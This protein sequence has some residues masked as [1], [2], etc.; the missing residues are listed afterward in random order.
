MTDVEDTCDKRGVETPLFNL[1]VKSRS[2]AELSVFGLS[3]GWWSTLSRLLSLCTQAV[4]VC[5]CTLGLVALVGWPV[6]NASIVTHLNKKPSFVTVCEELEF[7]GFEYGWP[8]ASTPTYCS[9]IL[10]QIHV[11]ITLSQVPIPHT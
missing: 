7:H 3:G 6:Q 4:C 5:F 10:H 1:G 11:W 9:I 2:D 8:Q